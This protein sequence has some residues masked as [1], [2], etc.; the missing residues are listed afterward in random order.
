MP[1]VVSPGGIL[2]PAVKT[3]TVMQTKTSLRSVL[4]L[5]MEVEAVNFI[6][7]HLP[8]TSQPIMSQWVVMCPGLDQWEAEDDSSQEASKV[9]RPKLVLSFCCFISFNIQD[10]TRRY[11]AY[12]MI[13]FE[14][15][16]GVWRISR[17]QVQST[18]SAL[19][20]ELKHFLMNWNGTSLNI[21]I[22]ERTF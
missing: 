7:W 9:F 16:W 8:L 13:E 12:V 14:A 5:I 21:E 2:Y 17:Y 19:F 1:S 18:P 22:F 4:M 6:L 20:N 10:P 15:V 3:W 11:A